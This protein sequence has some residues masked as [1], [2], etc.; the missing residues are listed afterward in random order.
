MV[1]DAGEDVLIAKP[2]IVD[3][4]VIAPDLQTAQRSKTYSES[5]GEMTLVL[6]LYDSLTHD[7][8][9]T[10]RDRKQTVSVI[11]K[12]AMLNGAPV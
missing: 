9:V 11:I 3:L 10:V 7:K 6:E 4:D 8:I 2:A 12:R 1:E 5:A